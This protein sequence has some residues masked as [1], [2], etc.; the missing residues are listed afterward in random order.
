LPNRFVIAGAVV[1]V[2]ALGACGGSDDASPSSSST[3]SASKASGPTLGEELCTAYLEATKDEDQPSV[4][5]R[6]ALREMEDV[7]TDGA[8]RAKLRA[9]TEA[10]REVERVW[11]D[12]AATTPDAFSRAARDASVAYAEAAEAAGVNPCPRPDA[13]DTTTTSAGGATKPTWSFNTVDL[14]TSGGGLWVYFDAACPDGTELTGVTDPWVANPGAPG[15]S[16]A[17]LVEGLAEGAPFTA[18]AADEAFA[19]KP[20]F[21]GTCA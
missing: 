3:P 17:A 5:A 12:P 8:D 16:F 11:T 20:D 18:I 21:N 1:A 13:A 14:P 6:N 7:T 2:L 19:A 4:Q 15:V 9:V 10:F